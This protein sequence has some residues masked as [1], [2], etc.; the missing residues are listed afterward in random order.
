MGTTSLDYFFHD[1]YVIARKVKAEGRCLK[2]T[3]LVPENHEI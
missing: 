1:S 3:I 2:R